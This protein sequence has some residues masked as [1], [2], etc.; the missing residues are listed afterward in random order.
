MRLRKASGSCQQS[1]DPR[2]TEWGNPM[3]VMSHYFC[4][5]I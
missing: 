3:G 4:L 2:I 5:N 1:F